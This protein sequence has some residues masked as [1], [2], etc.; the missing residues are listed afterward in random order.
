MAV[1]GPSLGLS[2]EVRWKPFFLDGTLPGGEGKDKAAHYQQKFGA[3]R[4]AQML[5]M[6][7]RTFADAG[8]PSYNLGGKVGNTLDSHRLMEL[9]L[10]QGGPELQVS[11]WRGVGPAHTCEQQILALS[12]CVL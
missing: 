11:L 2:F 8:L 7:Q 3:A 1:A 6:M 12:S 5:P 4:V 10:Q 9:A